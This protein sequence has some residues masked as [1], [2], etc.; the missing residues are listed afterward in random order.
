MK[1]ILLLISILLF[2]TKLAYAQ[3]WEKDIIPIHKEF[4]ELY[5]IFEANKLTNE[6]KRTGIP[7]LPEDYSKRIKKLLNDANELSED[8]PYAEKALSGVGGLSLLGVGYVSGE[9]VARNIMLFQRQYI[10]DFSQINFIRN[11]DNYSIAELRESYDIDRIDDLD[12]LLSLRKSKEL[13]EIREIW[14]M[15]NVNDTDNGFS[16]DKNVLNKKHLNLDRDYY[17]IYGN[18]HVVYFEEIYNKEGTKQIGEGGATHIRFSPDILNMPN[19]LTTQ[20]DII[21]MIKMLT[22]EDTKLIKAYKPSEIDPIYKSNKVVLILESSTVSN[23]LKNGNFNVF[24][25]EKEKKSYFMAIYDRFNHDL[26]TGEKADI[27]TNLIIT[28]DRLLAP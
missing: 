4:L 15:T 9:N 11:L 26:L 2:A 20:H 16:Q 23:R 24:S 8:N 14:D 10:Y 7:G 12:K 13:Q 1:K 27:A 17:K 21:K 28:L 25:D 22:P 6:F 18:D 3:S 5:E 19:I